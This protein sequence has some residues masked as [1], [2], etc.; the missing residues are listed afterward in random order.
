MKMK[1]KGEKEEK[2]QRKI[3]GKYYKMNIETNIKEKQIY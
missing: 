2:L 3:E 1:K